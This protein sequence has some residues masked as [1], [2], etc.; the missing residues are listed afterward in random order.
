MISSER[1]DSTFTRSSER[2]DSIEGGFVSFFNEFDTEKGT[3][4]VDL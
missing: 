2:L 4:L 3:M 1:I